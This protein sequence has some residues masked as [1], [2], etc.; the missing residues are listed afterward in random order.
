MKDQPFADVEDLLCAMAKAPAVPLGMVQADFKLAPGVVMGAYVL[1]E[2]LGTGGFADV[3]RAVRRD[4]VQVALKVLHNRICQDA[5]LLASFEQ[6]VWTLARMEHPG[7][8]EIL[9][10]GQVLCQHRP[11]YAMEILRGG[12]MELRSYPLDEALALFD[13][14]LGVLAYIHARGLVHRDLK[15]DNVFVLTGP[16]SPQRL[17]IMDFGIAYVAQHIAREL[18]SQDANAGKEGHVLGT[19]THMAPEQAKGLHRAT[20]PATDLYA[21]GVMLY[22]V[23]TGQLPFIADM[24]IQYIFMHVEKP[25]PPMQLQPELA[26]LEALVM[27]LLAK[28]YHERHECASDVQ[29]EVRE[30]IDGLPPKVLRVPLTNPNVDPQAHTLEVSKP[31]VEHTPTLEFQ[32]TLVSL[33]DT[34]PS[35]LPPPTISGNATTPSSPAETLL[36]RHDVI[37]EPGSWELRR[38]RELPLVGREVICDALWRALGEAR[39]ESQPR[40]ALVMG[41]RGMGKQ[42]ITRWLVHTALEKGQARVLHLDLATRPA[43]GTAMH[44]ALYRVLRQPHEEPHFVQERIQETL[45]FPNPEDTRALTDFLCQQGA[46]NTYTT[47]EDTTERLWPLW[48]RALFQLVRQPS[49]RPVIVW[50]DG[51]PMGSLQA[52]VDWVRWLL[53]EAKTAQQPLMVLWA[54]APDGQNESSAAQLRSLVH[55]PQVRMHRL[56]PLDVESQRALL[57]LMEPKLASASASQFVE[58]CQGNPYWLREALFGCWAS[59]ALHERRGEVQLVHEGPLPIPTDVLGALRYRLEVLCMQAPDPMIAARAWQLLALLGV[60]FSRQQVEFCLQG[61]TWTPEFLVEQ[62]W[63]ELR[64]VTHSPRYTFRDRDLREAL[65]EQVDEDNLREDLVPSCLKLRLEESL[66]ALGCADWENASHELHTALSLQTKHPPSQ[67]H[68]WHLFVI[69]AMAR[70]AYRKRQEM[71]LRGLATLLLRAPSESPWKERYIATARL[72]KGCA[73]LLEGELEE[74]EH[75]LEMAGSTSEKGSAFICAQALMRWSEVSM[76]RR[77]FANARIYLDVAL[78]YI[79]KAQVHTQTNAGEGAHLFTS[80]HQQL[81]HLL[82]ADILRSRGELEQQAGDHT[83]SQQPLMEALGVYE[84]GD[85]FQGQVRAHILLMR[86]WRKHLT[87]EPQDAQVRQDAHK[88]L[89]HIE[90][91]LEHLD[92]PRGQALRAWEAAS[93]YEVEGDLQRARLFYHQ[94][95]A[96]YHDCGE[97]FDEGLVCNILGELYRTQGTTESRLQALQ[98]FATFR[99]AMKGS[100]FYESMALGSMA[101]TAFEAHDF[102]QAKALFKASLALLSPGEQEEHIEQAIMVNIGAGCA[103]GLTGQ[104]EDARQ[105]LSSAVL[106]SSSQSIGGDETKVMNEALTRLQGLLISPQLSFLVKRLLGLVENM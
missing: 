98:L 13:E 8:V 2:R 12:V 72:W 41:A 81:V 31:H 67:P 49:L 22:E 45:A 92:D 104:E 42:S 68:Q 10:F 86:M 32:D 19:V 38:V 28:G 102:T 27:R 65:L 39:D 74:A 58:R 87:K 46:P 17:K 24:A 103:A 95:R 11:W 77:D 70:V 36:V 15:S 25:P 80:Y 4:G 43:L 84:Q 3:W 60:D 16:E 6:E 18:P 83:A 101:W 82:Q 71:T 62:A 26:Q 40:A 7:I 78:S 61:T 73:A 54:L 21:V 100:P 75:E 64:E 35:T 66:R 51:Q 20:G 50:I 59:G 79:H 94:A 30:I 47:E 105:H 85:D 76:R 96:H 55:L 1:E 44:Q 29:R 89:H 9:D 53:E 23:L 48:S 57:S 56:E 33:N 97:T 88:H 91:L 63:L 99:E 14:F 69:D 90:R 106:L 5:A 34:H 52:L 93:L 37:A